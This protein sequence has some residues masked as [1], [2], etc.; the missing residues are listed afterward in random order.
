MK[1][2]LRVPAL[3]S[4]LRGFDED[5]PNRLAS[6]AIG[7]FELNRSYWSTKSTNGDLDGLPGNGIDGYRSKREPNVF[8]QQQLVDV[9]NQVKPG[10]SWKQE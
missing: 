2:W 10:K 7:H 9:G 1:P 4:L 3:L 5:Q 8:D 6:L